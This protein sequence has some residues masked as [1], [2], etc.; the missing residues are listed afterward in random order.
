VGEPRRQLQQLLAAARDQNVATAKGANVL[1]MAAW[2]GQRPTADYLMAKGFRPVPIKNLGEAG[3]KDELVHDL[4]PR[5]KAIGYDW[6]A[7]YAAKSGDAAGAQAAWAVAAPA[8]DEAL[9]ESRRVQAAYEK[10]L[11]KHTQVRNE[12][13]AGIA[14]LNVASALA[15]AGAGASYTTTYMLSLEADVEADRRVIAAMKAEIVEMEARAA[16]IRAQHLAKGTQGTAP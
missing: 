1:M 2:G 13:K 9:A 5:A 6:Y 3:I 10:A 14:I 7:Q 16:E 12:K 8:Y 4:A 15:S 11:A